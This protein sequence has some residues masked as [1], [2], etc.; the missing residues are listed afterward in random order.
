MRGNSA[1]S[2]TSTQAPSPYSPSPSA[3]LHYR[4]MSAKRNLETITSTASNAGKLVPPPRESRA[5][6]TRPTL[7][8]GT[9]ERI[10]W[11]VSRRAQSGNAA[12]SRRRALDPRE[13]QR[14]RAARGDDSDASHGQEGVAGRVAA[15]RD[16]AHR[17]HDALR[18]RH[19]RQRAPPVRQGAPPAARRSRA[20]ARRRAS[21]AFR[22]ARCA[23]ITRSCR[24]PSTRSRDRTFRSPP[25]RRDFPPGLS[26]I[27][28]R[29]DEIRASVAAGARE[30][31][32]VI[33]RAHVL[34]GN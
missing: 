12:R 13:S 6:E 29:V 34:T 33:T 32:I 22:S 24:P 1:R 27:E 9:T 16:H 31:D 25:C 26:P 21:S 7:V 15:P 28:Q 2:V 10:N 4:A 3:A 14:R 8:A 19:A 5:V 20:I 18:R 23:C 11:T 30:I 17:P